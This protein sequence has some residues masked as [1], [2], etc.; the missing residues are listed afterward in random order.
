MTGSAENIPAPDHVQEV[1]Q[2]GSGV[3]PVEDTPNPSAPVAAPVVKPKPQ[4]TPKSD[5]ERKSEQVTARCTVAQ[6]AR[7]SGILAANNCDIAG[8]A[9]LVYERLENDVIA[10]MLTGIK[11]K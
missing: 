4:F 3:P 10:R 8:F 5:D 9:L 1:E 7:I 11:T 6:K 2:P